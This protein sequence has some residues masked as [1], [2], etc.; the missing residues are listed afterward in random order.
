MSSRID[1]SSPV[2]I[3]LNVC[4]IAVQFTEDALRRVWHWYF[5]AGPMRKTTYQA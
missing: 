1:G 5:E 3:D 4:R 2:L